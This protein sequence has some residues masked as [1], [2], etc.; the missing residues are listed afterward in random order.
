MLDDTARFLANYMVM[1]PAS[2]L[3]I[4]AWVMAAWLQDVWDR[5]PH[6]CITPARRNVAARRGCWIC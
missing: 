1:P 5:F 6:L 4:S 2:V 3:V